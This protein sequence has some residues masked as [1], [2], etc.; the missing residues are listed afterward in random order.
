M[1]EYY[2]I[3]ASFNSIHFSN[4]IQIQ[5]VDNNNFWFS[6]MHKN[7]N[8]KFTL[9]EEISENNKILSLF[10]TDNKNEINNYIDLVKESFLKLLNEEITILQEDI[11]ILKSSNIYKENNREKQLNFILND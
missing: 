3:S 9:Y 5:E 10:I 11:N 2:L 1:K 7:D 4:G 8:N 6:L